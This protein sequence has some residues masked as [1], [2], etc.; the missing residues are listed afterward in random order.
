MKQIIWGHTL[1]EAQGNSK[2]NTFMNDEYKKKN[3][4]M[5][6]KLKRC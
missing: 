4:L 5:V 1:L 2:L 3:V 6:C